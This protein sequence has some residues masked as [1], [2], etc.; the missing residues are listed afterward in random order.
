MRS[1]AFRRH[2]LKRIKDKW[3]TIGIQWGLRD[4][5]IPF[6]NGGTFEDWVNR[7]AGNMP[8]CSNPRCCGNPRKL[9]HIT[10]QEL[11]ADIS[12]EEQIHEIKSV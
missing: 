1:R 3:R 5:G 11:R 10:E 2:Q 6:A 8:T 9:G 12:Q 7:T 4:D